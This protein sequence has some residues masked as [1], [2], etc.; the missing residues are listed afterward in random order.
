MNERQLNDTLIGIHHRLQWINDARERADWVKRCEAQ[1]MSET[2]W[3]RLIWMTEDLLDK[4]ETLGGRPCVP[5][6]AAGVSLRE[7]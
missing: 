1:H 3:A 6:C 5:H 2:E 4:V 7:E